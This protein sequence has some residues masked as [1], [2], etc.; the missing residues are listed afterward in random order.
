MSTTNHTLE[1][2][3]ALKEALATIEDYL[4][5]DHNGDPW[6]EDARSMGEMDINDYKIDG[7]LENAREVIAKATATQN[8]E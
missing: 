2:L 4:E 1:L 8:K 3:E 7:R 6:V 5:Y